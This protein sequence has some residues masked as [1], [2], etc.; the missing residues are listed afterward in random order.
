[1]GLN[2][3]QLLFCLEYQLWFSGISVAKLECI[4]DAFTGPYKVW[5]HLLDGTKW[6]DAFTGFSWS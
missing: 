3:N 2:Y 4:T 5:M 1:M 6:M